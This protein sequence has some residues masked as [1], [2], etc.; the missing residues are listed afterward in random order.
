VLLEDEEARIFL[1]H[2]ED[3]G[4]EPIISPRG[5]NH[6]GAILAD[7]ALQRRAKYK[8]VVRPRVVEL[9][10]AWPDADTVTTFAAHM[11]KEDVAVVLRW[12]S[13]AKLQVLAALTTAMQELGIDDVAELRSRFSSS[14]GSKLL[15]DRL[16][17]IRG[18]GPKTV[19]Y[20]AILSGSQ[21]RAA[22]DSHL[23]TFAKDAGLQPGSYEHLQQV[24][25][26]AADLRGCSPS[27]L[28][29]AIWEYMSSCS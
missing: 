19:D 23:Q 27:H 9:K 7:A 12:R 4:L 20:L 13:P 1:A 17:K 24:V 25:A 18:V 29:A 3:L 11:A 28:D 14:E 22:I 6:M 15:T 5:W 10:E 2:F 26:R 8:K 21:E 16:R